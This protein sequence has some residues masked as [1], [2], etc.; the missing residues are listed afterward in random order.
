MKNYNGK[1]ALA[2][3]LA[4]ALITSMVPV[5]AVSAF[6]NDV[7]SGS[8][9]FIDSGIRL[10]NT[11]YLE[12]DKLL[13]PQ[14]AIIHLSGE[15]STSVTY[16]A[17]YHLQ[18]EN[19]WSAITTI[20][21]GDDTL[22]FNAP[23]TGV[24]EMN[25]IAETADGVQSNVILTF[26]VFDELW[27]E[28][29]SQIFFDGFG[30]VNKPIEIYAFSSGGVYQDNTPELYS[31]EYKK[32]QEANW[33]IV[34]DFSE[35]QYTELNFTEPGEYLIKMSVK[36]AAD[37]ITSV[38]RQVTIY[39]ELENTSTISQNKIL[40]GNSVTLTASLKNYPE[41]QEI[42]PDFRYKP[43][44]S[45]NWNYIYPEDINAKSVEFTPKTT[46]KYDIA[47]DISL[48][49]GLEKEK[50]F[51]L[52]VADQL[53]SSIWIENPHDV[54]LFAPGDKITFYAD[55]YGGFDA[56]GYQYAYYLRYYD[57]DTQTFSD[58]QLVQD[59]TDQSEFE[60]TPTEAKDFEMTV[61]AKD[62]AGHTAFCEQPFYCIYAEP[63]TITAKASQ[64][65]ISAGST[66]TITAE[67]EGAYLYEEQENCYY[68]FSYHKKDSE[69]S[70][71]IESNPN[72][73]KIADLT[74]QEP[75]DYEIEVWAYDDAGREASTTLT[76]T[77][78]EPFGIMPLPD[79]EEYIQGEKVI[80]SANPEGGKAPYTFTY[81]A[82][83]YYTDETGEEQFERII[84]KENTNEDSITFTADKAGRYIVNVDAQ[85]S[86]GDET[87]GEWEFQVYNKLENTSYLS[88]E[89]I[90]LGNAAVLYGQSTG[91][92]EN[93]QY[94]F[95][96]KE[97]SSSKWI[98]LAK[99]EDG[100]QTIRFIPQKI[101][102]YDI[103]IKVM[104]SSKTVAKKYFTL[105]ASEYFNIDFSYD[106]GDIKE[107]EK[108]NFETTAEGG[109]AP[110][111][112]TYFY[113]RYFDGNN[114]PPKV[115][116]QENSSD[117]KFVFT[118]EGF[119]AYLV[120]VTVTDANG[121][122]MTT[123]REIY[124]YRNFTNIS[125][126][127]SENIKLGESVKVTGA[128]D[129]GSYSQNISYSYLYKLSTDTKWT[130]IS[131]Y[132][133]S[134]PSV[135]ITPKTAGTYDI[136]VKAKT[137]EDGEAKKYFT[138]NVAEKLSMTASLSAESVVLGKSITVTAEGKGGS[139]NYTYAC[140]YKKTTDKNWT[141]VSGFGSKNTFTVTP[142]K[143]TEYQI[144]VKTKDASGTTVKQYLNI[145]AYNAL[146]NTSIVCNATGAGADTLDIK[147]GEQFMVNPSSTGGQ[148]SVQ[149]SCFYK[150]STDTKWLTAKSAD[151]HLAYY[152]TPAKTAK[153]NICVY[154]TDESGTTAK[155]YLTVNVLAAE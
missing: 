44:D 31:F 129:G 8:T 37:N 65:E 103:C 100:N 5:S 135:S 114:N 108:I 22:Y 121:S 89:N 19:D 126:I 58:W 45:E 127:S 1:K 148:G 141:T 118:P 73:P 68:N 23:Q 24:Y 69:T 39:D 11:S 111:K 81:S 79:K 93:K 17:F 38:Q 49:N 116:V 131:S 155:K 151:T 2:T 117:S 46:G 104:D 16:K 50:T 61:M 134:K 139:G 74:L 90:T 112:Y 4:A 125:E 54:N 78:S 15:Y 120:G 40:L 53:F 145:T 101:G 97:K 67:S 137:P 66:V 132:A 142:K 21:D 28:S 152:I 35:Q 55:A 107:N 95:F 71:D 34:S 7:T 153:Y 9:T 86:F 20:D 29:E 150:K 72:N 42:W 136:C 18:G 147:F 85:D 51:T 149:Y 154:A 10:V 64:N 32:I 94:A 63:F 96:Y 84:L 57:K 140:Y 122:E 25:I 87:A 48:N 109:T 123:E 115:I 27:I 14:S 88:E 92:F 133:N 75:G 91:G 36:D 33:T 102:T 62:S 77:V 143:A 130:V 6:N 119:G 128:V 30:Y 60:Y 47:I 99:Y 98:T 56:D 83:F 41:D 82:D 146:K 43:V 110:Y 138:L 124:V 12:K 106:K 3:I 113:T 76:V 59:F 144:C 105:K 80:F 70:Y 26:E 13:L 52:E